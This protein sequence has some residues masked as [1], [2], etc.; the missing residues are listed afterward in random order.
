MCNIVPAGKDVF[1]YKIFGALLRFI[2]NGFGSAQAATGSSAAAAASDVR[3]AAHACCAYGAV[4][5]IHYILVDIAEEARTGNLT[6][7]KDHA[8]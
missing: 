7:Y 4:S 3:K 2:R 1:W 6:H 8:L 5:A